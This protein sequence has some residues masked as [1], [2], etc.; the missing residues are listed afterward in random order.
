M[1]H[2][3]RDELYEAIDEILQ[4]SLEETKLCTPGLDDSMSIPS[5][6]LDTIN[7]EILDLILD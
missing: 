3:T 5:W 1:K 2:F 4:R 7:N 6:E